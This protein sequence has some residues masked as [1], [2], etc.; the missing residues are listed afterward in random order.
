[1]AEEVKLFGVWGSPFSRRVEIALKLKGVDYE[2]VEED[3]SNKSPLLLKYNPVHKKVPAF[4]HNG[5]AIAESQVILEY[6]DETWKNSPI[7]PKD[8]YGRAQAR[9]WASF[10][11]EKSMGVTLQPTILENVDVKGIVAHQ[12]LPALWKASWPCEDHE[13]VKD[14]AREHLK[15]LENELKDKKFF[16]GETV[17]L[18]DIVANFIAYWLPRIQKATG[19]ELLTEEK[20]PKLYQWG[21]EFENHG[22]VKEKLPPSDKLIAFFK[23]RFES[24]ST[25]K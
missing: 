5:K 2:Y 25:S 1:M 13:K 22:V 17:G 20:Y 21:H 7:L 18:V 8:P 24:V 16:G 12:C 4:V 3:L 15:T 9:F 14:E 23:D 6:I 11:D 10:I 19:A